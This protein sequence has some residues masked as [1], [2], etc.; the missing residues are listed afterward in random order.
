MFIYYSIDIDL[1]DRFNSAEVVL[2]AEDVNDH[3]PVFEHRE[4]SVAVNESSLINHQ[5]L[6]LTAT[7]DD[8]GSTYT[9]GVW[10]RGGVCGIGG[11]CVV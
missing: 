5:F 6:R 2:I 4:Y 9:S 8:E 7:D 3:S 10:Y 11:V 1:F